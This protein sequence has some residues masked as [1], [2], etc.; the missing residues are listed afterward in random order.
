MEA[1]K[2]LVARREAREFGVQM[3]ESTHSRLNLILQFL[4]QEQKDGKYHIEDVLDTAVN[5][6]ANQIVGFED[7]VAN[8]PKPA[9]K[10]AYKRRTNDAE[11]ENKT[12]KRG[13]V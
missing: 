12:L 2:S 11:K 8:V 5:L 3:Y 13:K 10:R 4:N 6:I 9:V 1:L 7:F